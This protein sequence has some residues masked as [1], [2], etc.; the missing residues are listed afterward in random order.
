MRALTLAPAWLLAAAQ[1]PSR[2]S[3]DGTL[4]A[5]MLQS[6]RRGLSTHD[7]DNLNVARATEA[8]D[9]CG[10]DASTCDE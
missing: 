10:A 2:R 4:N 7:V 6:H 1:E 3:D 9:P 5:S 8:V